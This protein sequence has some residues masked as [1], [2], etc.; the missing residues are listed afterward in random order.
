MIARPSPFDR[1]KKRD[2]SILWLDPLR[3]SGLLIHTEIAVSR[4]K[5]GAYEDV[6]NGTE[7]WNSTRSASKSKLQR[8][9]P[10]F[11]REIWKTCPYFVIFRP[12][13][14]LERAD[15]PGPNG[16]N[17]RCFLWRGHS[18]SGFSDSV[19]RMQCDHKPTMGRKRLDLSML[20]TSP[21]LANQQINTHS[22]FVSHKRV[23]EDSSRLV[24][25][26]TR[27]RR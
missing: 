4:R 12:Q 15:C 20:P 13:S 8:N 17:L 9:C 22:Q 24:R 25:E 7:G 6:R 19:G 14:G 26:K 23:C 2:Y 1:P 5:K 16:V 10:A 18:Q 21:F 27:A 11:C 3:F